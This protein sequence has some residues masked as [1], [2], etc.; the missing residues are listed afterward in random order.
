MRRTL[1]LAAALLVPLAAAAGLAAW[2]VSLVMPE[3]GF[4]V[5]GVIGL[6]LAGGVGLAVYLIGALA[7]R[8]PEVA[9][10]L[11]RLRR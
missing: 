4:I 8:L 11:R 5:P 9:G 6:A 10:V 3:P 7:L 1:F 2:L